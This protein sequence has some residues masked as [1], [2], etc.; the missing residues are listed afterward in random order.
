MRRYY[1]FAVV[2]VLVG[3][4]ALLLMRALE[5]ARG[6]MEETIVQAEAAAMRMGLIEVVAHRET[7]GG[8]LPK[9][10][11][12]VDWVATP[13]ANYVGERD[14]RPDETSIWYFDRR[15]GELIFVFRD[16][17]RA[18]FR[19]SR[20]ASVDTQRAVVAGVGLLRLEDRRE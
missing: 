17:R 5:R 6:D 8:E 9:S 20:D 11:N 2:V 18:R 16:G 13:P 10:T 15:A 3:L 12:P 1:E 19:L 14:G 4:L 7:Y